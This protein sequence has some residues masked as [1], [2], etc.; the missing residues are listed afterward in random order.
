MGK[1]TSGNKHMATKLD[2]VLACEVPMQYKSKQV[3]IMLL[4]YCRY[5]NDTRTENSQRNETSIGYIMNENHV[6]CRLFK[7]M[8]FS[9]LMY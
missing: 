9:V 1:N 6:V 2:I 4:S 8:C 3:F 5:N 7:F